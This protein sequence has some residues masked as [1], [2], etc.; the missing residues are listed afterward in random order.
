MAWNL[1]E[2]GSLRKLQVG[3]FSPHMGLLRAKHCRTLRVPTYKKQ[4]RPR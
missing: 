3:G 4:H 2:E 1:L